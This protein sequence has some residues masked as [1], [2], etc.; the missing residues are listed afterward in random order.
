[1]QSTGKV[2]SFEKMYSQGIESSNSVPMLQAKGLMDTE[3]SQLLAEAP[4]E[5]D[6][7]LDFVPDPDFLKKINQNMLLN[8]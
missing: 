5:L 7:S 4:K 8:D 3:R 6:E 1:L 2:E